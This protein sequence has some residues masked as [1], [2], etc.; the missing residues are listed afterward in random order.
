[1][2]DFAFRMSNGVPKVTAFQPERAQFRFVY[3]TTANQPF[4]EALG[5]GNVDTSGAALQRLLPLRIDRS[6]PLGILTFRD[7]GEYP[8]PRYC[9]PG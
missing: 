9:A 3:A 1:M 5:I 2:K 4:Y 6:S 8:T 7:E